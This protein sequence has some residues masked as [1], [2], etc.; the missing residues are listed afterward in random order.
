M[1]GSSNTAAGRVILTIVAIMA[2]VGPYIADWNETHIYNPLWLPHAKFHDAQTMTTGA[3]LGALAL[4]LLYR[5]EP[6][7]STDTAFLVALLDAFYYVT[8]LCAWF[9]PETA[10]QDPPSDPYWFP[11][12]FAACPI[13]GL[14]GLAYWLEKRRLE[15]IKQA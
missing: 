4:Y 8:Q 11:Q 9:Y 7:Y 12:A 6:K 15:G 2:M 14:C 5:P 10:A 1:P 13:V 3:L